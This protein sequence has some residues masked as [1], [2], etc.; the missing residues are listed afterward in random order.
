MRKSILSA[1]VEMD[2]EQVRMAMQQGIKEGLS[3]EIPPELAGKPGEVPTS[4]EK[5]G[6][7][8]KQEPAESLEP[9]V[10]PEGSK[11]EN[12][13]DSQLLDLA[14]KLLTQSQAPQRSFLDSE[15]KPNHGPRRR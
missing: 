8:P 14:T 2:P 1:D 13:P 10:T 7:S 11:Q 4:S 6:V 5:E 3:S 12:A 15:T 9:E